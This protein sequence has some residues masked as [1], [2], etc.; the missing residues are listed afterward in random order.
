MKKGNIIQFVNFITDLEVEEFV[1]KWEAF[2]REAMPGASPMFLQLLSEKGRYKY[3]SKHECKDDDF[4]FAFKKGRNSD[5]FPEQKARIVQAGGYAA[6]QV[7]YRHPNKNGDLTIIAFVGHNE[8]DI[9]F[10]RQL[11]TYRHLNIY[12]AYYES[13]TYGYILEFCTPEIDAPNLLQQ[14][15]SRRGTEAALYRECVASPA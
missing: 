6:V 10:Y 14:I 2:A 3:V 7:D 9:D 1:V 13:C 12:Q 15:I 11:P 5:H 4:H 8:L